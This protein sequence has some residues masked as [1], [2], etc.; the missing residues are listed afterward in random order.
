MPRRFGAFI[1]ASGAS[2]QSKSLSAHLAEGGYMADVQVTPLRLM[3]SPPVVM[4]RSLL[5]RNGP[6]LVNYAA[7]SRAVCLA[8]R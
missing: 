5:K 4:A 7:A 8:I 1:A 2:R 6:L 3:K